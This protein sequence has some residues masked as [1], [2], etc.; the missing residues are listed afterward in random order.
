MQFRV[1]YNTGFTQQHLKHQTTTNKSSCTLDCYQCLS[2]A[3]GTPQSIARHSVVGTR[4]S[5][6]AMCASNWFAAL[7]YW[8]V[9]LVSS[10]FGFGCFPQT[11]QL[12]IL[13]IAIFYATAL[14]RR[15]LTQRSAAVY[16][17]C[18]NFRAEQNRANKW[19]ARCV[20]LR[21]VAFCSLFSVWFFRVTVQYR[22]QQSATSSPAKFLLH[23]PSNLQAQYKQKPS[24]TR[25]RTRTRTWIYCVHSIKYSYCLLTL[26]IFWIIFMFVTSSLQVSRDWA[27]RLSW[28]VSSWLNC[29]AQSTPGHLSASRRH[30]QCASVLS[31][32]S[33]VPYPPYVQ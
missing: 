11:L 1:L 26:V 21:S 22:I 4:Q 6:S 13:H 25:T 20:A 24:Y 9:R 7:Q 2:G 32:S 8:F 14:V 29:T 12:S 30:S 19:R 31:F 27:S 5:A 23:H 28:T 3:C 10:R 17:N 15:L 16:S 33:P 18:T